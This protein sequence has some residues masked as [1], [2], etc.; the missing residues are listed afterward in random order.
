[1]I[2]QKDTAIIKRHGDICAETEIIWRRIEVGSKATAAGGGDKGAERV[3]A[4]EILRSEQ[5]AKNFG[6]RNR[7]AKRALPAAE[8]A[9]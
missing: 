3:A 9:S 8:K 7:G 4:V 6:H 5:R 2:F 1:M